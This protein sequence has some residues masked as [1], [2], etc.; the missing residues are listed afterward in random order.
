MRV[1]SPKVVADDV[2]VVLDHPAPHGRPAAVRLH[3]LLLPEE[4]GALAELPGLLVVV[5]SELGEEDLV[6]VLGQAAL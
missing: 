4:G 5:H 1:L 6:F 3:L 2:S